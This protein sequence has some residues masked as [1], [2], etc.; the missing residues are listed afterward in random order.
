MPKDSF[1]FPIVQSIHLVGLTVLVGTIALI[2]LRLLG[3]GI[4]HQTAAAVAGGLEPWTM[5]GFVT[6]AVTGPLLFSSDPTRYLNNPAFV[7]K[8]VLLFAAIITHFTF[9]RHV[10]GQR[11]A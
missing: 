10:T 2:D 7:V 1:L 4:R 9:Q 3:F 6:I 5:A 11:D 8:M